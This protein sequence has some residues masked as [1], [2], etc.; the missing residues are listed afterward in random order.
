MKVIKFISNLTS[1]FLVFVLSLLICKL[2]LNG[3]DLSG[4]L[5][6][7]VILAGDKLELSVRFRLKARFLTLLLIVILVGDYPVFAKY[8]PSFKWNTIETPHFYI[9]YHQ[10]EEQ[11]SAKVAQISEDVHERLV[12]RIKWEPKEKTHLVLID[13]KD[14]ANGNATPF[15][16]NKMNIYLTKPAG[17]LH[18]GA[19]D[20]WLRLLIT[21]E[22]THI[23]QMDMVNGLPKKIQNIFGR[24]YFPNMFQPIW[25]VEG[26]ATFE[27]TEQTSAGRGNS[28]YPDMVLRMA[29]LENEFPGLDKMSNLPYQWPSSDMPYLFG[30][31]FIRFIRDKYGRDKLAGI[32][33]EYSGRWFPFLVNSTGERVLNETYSNLYLEWKNELVIK[34]KKKKKEIQS[35]GL[36]GSSP[37]TEI[38]DINISPSFSPDGKYIAYTVSNNDEFPGIYIMNSDGSGKKKIVKNIFPS[39]TGSG[40]VWSPDGMKL[41]YTKMETNRNTNLFNDIYYYDLKLKKEIRITNG[42]RARDP[43]ISPDGKKIIFVV[44]K[45]GITRLAEMDISQGKVKYDEDKVKYL[46]KESEYQY[47]NPVFDPFGNKILVNV[48]QPGGYISLWIVDIEGNKVKELFNDR[49]LDITP[50]WSPDGKYVYFSSDRG[51]IYNLY[52]YEIEK[53]KLFQVTNVLG[54]AFMPSPSPDGIKI[55]F[56]NYT[57]K[58][59]DIHTIKIDKN[60]WKEAEEYRSKYKDAEYEKKQVE[61]KNYPYSP[62]SSIYPRYWFPSVECNSESGIMLGALTSGEDALQE[63]KYSATV[64]YGPDKGRVWYRLNYIYD[65]FYPTFKVDVSDY[66]KSYGDFFV[67]KSGDEKKKYI[68]KNRI[69]DISVSLPVISAQRKQKISLAYK[70]NK[71]SSLSGVTPWPGYN[72]PVPDK[73]KLASGRILYKFDNSKK[74]NFSVSREHGRVFELGYERSDKIFGSYFKFNKYTVDWH[75][76]ISMPWKHQILKSRIFAGA[77]D[78]DFISQGAFQLGGDIPGEVTSSV[79]EQAVNLRGYSANAFYGKKTALLSLEYR[80]PIK[81]YEKGHE[82]NPVYFRKLHGAV[83]AE[84]GNAWNGSSFHSSDLKRSAGIEISYDLSIAYLFPVTVRLG[85]ANGFDERGKAIVCLGVGTP[86][87]F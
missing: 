18:M 12:P 80:F 63:H 39:L 42:L 35:R 29:S 34:Y 74:Y 72:G 84:A 83:F 9:H 23:L 75:E 79:E 64:N 14:S 55:V 71:L 50:K 46:T 73:G 2:E 33:V 59:Y 38:G 16:Y 32:S 65:G 4:S 77:S 10:G 21:H 27:E 3:S 61:K 1:L 11:I 17:M 66:D 24:L 78:G 43:D 86:V 81:I 51:G 52:A 82:L 37:L 45:L 49:A 31:S 62:A 36:S 47:Q 22:Y 76:Y 30:E 70:W 7:I 67:S 85:F 68:E 25:L 60:K 69:Y 6:L 57:S 40:V 48:W 13:S 44:N 15:L 54:G 56:S 26:L 58:G 28:A 20:D 87:E 41:F 8:D 19:Y 53:A 5:L